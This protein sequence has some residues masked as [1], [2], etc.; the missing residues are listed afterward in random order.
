M[1]FGT[2]FLLLALAV[3]A[4][5]RHPTYPPRPAPHDSTPADDPS[6]PPDTGDIH[7]PL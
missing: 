4:C 5:S 3:S 2:A 1:R 6:T 7:I